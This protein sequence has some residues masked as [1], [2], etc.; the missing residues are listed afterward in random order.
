MLMGGP[1]PH[2]VLRGWLYG[3]SRLRDKQEV[4]A[5]N[6]Q[7][8]ASGWPAP[9]FAGSP[10]KRHVKAGDGKRGFGV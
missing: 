2:A 1:V 6:R 8:R 9:P 5:W 7:R 3:P 4:K 10:T